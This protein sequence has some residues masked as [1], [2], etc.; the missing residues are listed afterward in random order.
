MYFPELAIGLLLFTSGF[1][2]NH[3]WMNL[4]EKSAARRLIAI[5]QIECRGIYK[6][7]DEL[8]ELEKTLQ[9]D[10]SVL[11]AEKP[12]LMH[13]LEGHLHWLTKL[14]DEL[15]VISPHFLDYSNKQKMRRRR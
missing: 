7:I 2:A 6:R 8:E 13:G 11:L 15:E 4:R 5:V 14:V 10:A 12:W 1:I 3:A 9:S